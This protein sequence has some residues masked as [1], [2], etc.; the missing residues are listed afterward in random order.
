MGK[1][2]LST[3]IRR[4]VVNQGHMVLEFNLEMGRDEIGERELAYRAGIN[5]RK[6]MAAK[7][8]SKDELSRV[9]ASA[10]S[11]RPGL[12][13]VWD[14]VFS[15]SGIVDICRLQKAKADE[16]KKHIGLVVIDYLQLLSD[17]G[18]QARHESVSACSRLTKLLS[19]EMGCAVLAL[20]QLNRN[21][22][23][24]KNEPC[25]ARPIMSDIRESGSIEQDA[26]CIMF[27]Y[28][29][30]HYNPTT[31]PE[32]AELNIAKQR[33]GPTGTVRVRFNPRQTYFD[34]WPEDS[35]GLENG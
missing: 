21:C 9:M 19:K 22:E 26:D 20:S 13:M 11:V 15:M 3:T 17:T 2:A 12:W 10:G 29:D 7:E 1:S 6:V 4:S 18:T 34:D 24:R 14:N 25:G 23:Y 27:L 33:A 16:E 31:P 5:L 28:R 30:N 32:E 8:V 35:N